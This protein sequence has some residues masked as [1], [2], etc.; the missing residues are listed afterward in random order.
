MRPRSTFYHSCLRGSQERM[1]DREYS[2]YSD[3]DVETETRN[4]KGILPKSI[5]KNVLD[6]NM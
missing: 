5:K 6:I 4:Q 1:S 3:E 2:E